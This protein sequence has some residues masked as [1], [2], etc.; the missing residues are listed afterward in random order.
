MRR[1]IAV[2]T[3]AVLACG[4]TL[5]GC[6]DGS[7]EKQ[8]G[9][10]PRPSTSASTGADPA[11]G[12]AVVTTVTGRLPAQRRTALAEAITA[13]VDG[14]L[15]G[16]YL[17]DFPRADY[18]PAF[19]G[20]TAG[21]AARAQRQLA[22]MSNAAVSDR[23]DEASATRRSISLDVLAVGQQP[24][25]VTATV[26]LAFRT[27]GEL[28]AAQ[29]VSGTLDLT[30]VGGGWRIFGYRVSRTPVAAA[31]PSA[32]PSATPSATPSA[33]PSATPSATPAATS[34]STS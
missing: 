28:A 6:S 12:P 11:V 5:A 17:G 27:T 14:W 10:A 19:T 20:F 2:A 23:I 22:L 31:T 7:G 25:G 29:E 1:G 32:I 3:A 21:A 4:T 8:A 13:V 26:D 15:D 18:A 30:P 9:S 24:V 16:A 33:A 34:E